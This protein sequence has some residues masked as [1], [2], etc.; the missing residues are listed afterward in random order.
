MPLPMKVLPTRIT[1]TPS[2]LSTRSRS[3]NDA[4][5]WETN[6]AG[7]VSLPGSTGVVTVTMPTLDNGGHAAG[8]ALKIASGQAL[9]KVLKREGNCLG[10]AT[11]TDLMLAC[12]PAG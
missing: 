5:P 3:G 1:V 10:K 4:P 2:P 12:A 7:P 8:L 11:N 6:I 9:F